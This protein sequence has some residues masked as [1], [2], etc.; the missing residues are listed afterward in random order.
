MEK[1]GGLIV[2]N[3]ETENLTSLIP[4]RPLSPPDRYALLK[5]VGLEFDQSKRIWKDS[6]GRGIGEGVMRALCDE[7]FHRYI[8]RI[9]SEKD[10]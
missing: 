8:D 5:S 7:A 10:F 9:R 3:Q 4:E 2:M 1:D 6:D